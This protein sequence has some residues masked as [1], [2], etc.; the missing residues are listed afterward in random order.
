[1]Y[2][3]YVDVN[4][5]IQWVAYNAD[6]SKVANGVVRNAGNYDNIAV[7]QFPDQNGRLTKYVYAHQINN[8][9][10]IYKSNDIEPDYFI[11]S[12][13]SYYDNDLAGPI[14]SSVLVLPNNDMID[15][16]QRNQWVARNMRDPWGGIKCRTENL[17]LQSNQNGIKLG[18]R[19]QYTDLQDGRYNIFYLDNSSRVRYVTY[20]PNAPYF[21][22]PITPS[23]PIVPAFATPA[24]VIVKDFAVNPAT[25][26]IYYGDATTK[27]LYQIW[28]VNHNPKNAS[29]S[30]PKVIPY[31]G[32]STDATG[33]GHYTFASPHLY[34]VANTDYN[35][36]SPMFN[37]WYYEGCT[38]ANPRMD[39]NEDEKITASTSDYPESLNSSA[40]SCVPNPALD[41]SSVTFRLQETSNVK[42]TL[43]DASGKE[44]G[45]IAEGNFS[46]Q[47]SI[48]IPQHLKQ[49]LYIILM[50]A[51]NKTYTTRLIIT[52]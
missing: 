50:N 41:N 45:T 48:S 52:N 19:V 2:A 5:L 4:N 26:T 12:T 38:P 49:G 17:T 8:T 14:Y 37:T 24:G 25:G 30:V 15:L 10:F 34:Y 35:V 22:T 16:Y 1:V 39:A 23:M 9:N 20:T 29:Y 27:K 31:T 46:G 42:I 33:F 51:N 43:M 7:A 47:N 11:N 21:S 36:T 13:A 28:D 6:G 40:L 44:L 18:T 3:Y 32:S